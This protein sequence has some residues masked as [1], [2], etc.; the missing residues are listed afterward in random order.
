MVLFNFIADAR[1]PEQVSA[2]TDEV[3]WVEEDCGDG[4][5]VVVT[6]AGVRGV[7]PTAYIGTKAVV[8][9]EQASHA[10]VHGHGHGHEHGH[11]SHGGDATATAA[12]T[13][14]PAPPLP[15]HAHAHAA[16]AAHAS[17]G[18]F[19]ATRIKPRLVALRHLFIR[20]TTQRLYAFAELAVLGVKVLLFSVLAPMLVHLF[21]IITRA[22]SYTTVASGATRTVYVAGVAWTL[23]SLK[24]DELDKVHEHVKVKL[25]RVRQERARRSSLSSAAAAAAA[26]S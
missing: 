10:H 13:T 20:S 12:P 23:P 19:F 8:E 21:R 18:G 1:E 5:S 24:D 15:T 11:A 26:G 25:E 4:W 14:G 6:R 17:S 7:V 16:A 22:E 2:L 9:Q 3:V